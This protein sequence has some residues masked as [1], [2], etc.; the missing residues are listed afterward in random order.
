[1]IN[2]AR[3]FQDIRLFKAVTGMTY[4]E[5]TALLPAVDA[6]LKQDALTNRSPRQRQQ[7]GGRTH[8]VTSEREKLFFILLSVKCYATCDVLAWLFDVDRAQPHRWV[9]TYLPVLEA[10]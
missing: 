6:V 9:S 3:C 1:M 8:P 5:F 2:I 10:A 7:G 4:V